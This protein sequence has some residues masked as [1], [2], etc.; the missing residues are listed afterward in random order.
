MSLS[1]WRLRVFQPA[2]V[3]IWELKSPIT[4]GCR[5]PD[6]P[7]ASGAFALQSLTRRDFRKGMGCDHAFIVM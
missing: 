6:G 1:R 4:S 3:L 7:S 5:K 2:M